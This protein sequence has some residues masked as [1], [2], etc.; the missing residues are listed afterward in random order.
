MLM[1]MHLFVRKGTRSS[2]YLR[3]PEH[4]ILAFL[5]ELNLFALALT[6]VI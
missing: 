5:Y 4:L 3:Y 1:M 6:L 2:G